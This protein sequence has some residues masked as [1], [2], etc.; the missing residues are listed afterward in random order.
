MDRGK[1]NEP[2]FAVCIDNRDYVASLQRRKI[3]RAPR[4]PPPHCIGRS[5]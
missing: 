1:P 3:Y 4:T 5:A 2:R